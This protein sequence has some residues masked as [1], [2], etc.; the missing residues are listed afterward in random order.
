MSPLSCTFP[1]PHLLFLVDCVNA[2]NLVEEGGEPTAAP[3]SFVNQRRKLLI[4][5]TTTAEAATRTTITT[6]R[7]SQGQHT[8]VT[9][10]WSTQLRSIVS[11]WLRFRTRKAN[12]TRNR[13]ENQNETQLRRACD[14]RLS[15]ILSLSLSLYIYV[16]IIYVY[17]LYSVYGYTYVYL[18]I[19]PVYRTRRVFVSLYLPYY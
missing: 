4:T 3:S 18:Y 7:T 13:T 19:C 15:H 9:V 16:Y 14:L 10:M 11:M 12:E 6:T 2:C 1:L 17:V 5:P 8:T